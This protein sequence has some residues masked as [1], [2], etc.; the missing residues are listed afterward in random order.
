[1]L[2][3][4]KKEEKTF[5]SELYI[6]EDLYIKNIEN[7]TTLKLCT[8][9]FFNGEIFDSFK[10]SDDESIKIEKQDEIDIMGELAESEVLITDYSSVGYDFTFL[11]KPVILFQQDLEAYMEKREF[12]RE[13]EELDE[14]NIIHSYDLVKTIVTE[15][16]G[17]NPFFKAYSFA[18]CIRSGIQLDP[19]NAPTFPAL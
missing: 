4:L 11:E 6:I 2:N 14:H 5:S 13:K 10:K 12:Y 15:T 3:R 8:H 17:I 19:P 16:Y 7:N 18:S 9:Q 1:M